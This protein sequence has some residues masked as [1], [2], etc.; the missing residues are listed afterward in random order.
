MQSEANDDAAISDVAALMSEVPAVVLVSPLCVCAVDV[1]M[2]VEL[3]APLALVDGC[4]VDVRVVLPASPGHLVAVFAGSTIGSFASNTFV[5]ARRARDKQCRPTKRIS[6]SHKFA[7]YI[8]LP[9]ELQVLPALVV[10]DIGRRS[11]WRE[12]DDRR[13]IA[14]MRIGT[15]GKDLHCRVSGFCINGE[16]INFVVLQIN[17][18]VL[19][20][21]T[22]DLVV[23]DVERMIRLRSNLERVPVDQQQIYRIVHGAV[24]ASNVTR[25]RRREIAT[26]QSIDRSSSRTHTNN[27]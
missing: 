7:T 12:L 15:S 10:D 25:R 14:T 20:L 23:G 13:S 8:D 19:V 22:A 24:S 16:C 11:V 3:V 2:P 18:F 27:D 6:T 9:A 1:D 26:R 21:T 5:F 17:L 4:C